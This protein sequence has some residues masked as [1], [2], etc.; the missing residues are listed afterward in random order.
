MFTF[1]PLKQKKMYNSII[2]SSIIIAGV[3]SHSGE[4]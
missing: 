2:I 3:I 4:E 1:A